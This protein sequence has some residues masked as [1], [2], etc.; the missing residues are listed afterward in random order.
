LLPSFQSLIRPFVKA[1]LASAAILVPGVLVAPNLSVA[2]GLAISA[3]IA[4][5]VA[6]LEAADK[7]FSP[8][9]KTA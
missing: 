9:T 5:V 1:F 6:G 7:A 3:M 4:A 8:K 2:T